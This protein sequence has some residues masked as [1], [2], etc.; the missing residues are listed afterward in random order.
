MKRYCIY[1]HDEFPAFLG[2]SP[3]GE[4]IKYED[5]KTLLDG[6]I[7]RMHVCDGDIIVVQCPSF[8]SIAQMESIKEIIENVASGAGHKIGGV[9]VLSD[10]LK[11]SIMTN[12]PDVDVKQ[13]LEAYANGE[14][15]LNRIREELGMEPL[16]H[17]EADLFYPD[18][19]S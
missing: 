9:M 1:D 5:V 7:Q 17:P 2:E 14:T 6:Q 13:L 11:L 12:T 16:K 10:K 4:L 18:L 3:D 8:V 15:S 19:L